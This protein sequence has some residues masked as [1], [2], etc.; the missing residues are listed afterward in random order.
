MI[1]KL[2][3]S[4]SVKNVLGGDLESCSLSPMTGVYRN[5]C[6]NTGLD[7]PGAHIVCIEATAE[8]LAFSKARG[9]D[10]ST[11]KPDWALPGV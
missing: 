10:L 9:N 7:D 1:R 6:C 8:F 4:A 5:G 11:P 3:E 2:N